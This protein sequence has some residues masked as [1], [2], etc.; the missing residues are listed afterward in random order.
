MTIHKTTTTIKNNTNF[1]KISDSNRIKLFLQYK[2]AKYTSKYKNKLEKFDNSLNALREIELDFPHPIG[3]IG[4]VESLLQS[5]S[6]IIPKNIITQNNKDILLLFAEIF[7][8]IIEKIEYSDFLMGPTFT[9]AD[10]VLTG[11]LMAMQEI[12]EIKLPIELSTYIKKVQNKCI[13]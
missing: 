6:M 10:C 5:A 13:C 3:F 12:F 7:E 1:Q 11:D 9:V 4:P 2:H 8:E